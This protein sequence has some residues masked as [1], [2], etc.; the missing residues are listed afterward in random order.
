MAPARDSVKHDAITRV[1]VG[2]LDEY[3]LDYT[4][5]PQYV[6]A[7]LRRSQ[8]RDARNVAP[9]E[10][11][12]WLRAKLQAGDPLPAIVSTA[13]GEIVDGNTRAA[14]YQKE[15][16]QNGYVITTRK[17]AEQIGPALMKILGQRMNDHGKRLSRAETEASIRVL[18]TEGAT[19]ERIMQHLS[20]PQSRV[21]ELR[22]IMKAESKMAELGL[23]RNGFKTAH[24]KALGR[25]DLLAK[26]F[27]E[28]VKLSHDAGLSSGDLTNLAKRVKAE[29]S[30]E[31]QLQALASERNALSDQIRQHKLMGNGKPP[32]ARRAKQ[33][34]SQFLSV[35]TAP[36]TVVE[37]APE[38][39]EEQL[40]VLRQ[41]RQRLEALI[42]A[43]EAAAAE[44]GVTLL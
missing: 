33:S 43:Q 20:V 25:I 3:D 10:T 12:Q 24:M 1:L 35:T 18:I 28:L 36:E 32:A 34:L 27:A 11:V 44:A 26:P 5:D 17:T 29:N 7:N 16:R 40:S 39:M 15:K 21:H 37:R 13:D 6:L 22:A 42:E 19:T 23:G 38:R 30:E 14:A 8:V 4:E 9:A 2:I 41:S 31:A